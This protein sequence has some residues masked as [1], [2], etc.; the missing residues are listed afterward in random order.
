[1]IQTM[2]AGVFGAAAET[3]S[4]SSWMIA[5]R[6]WIAVARSKARFPVAIS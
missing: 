6:V 4:G 5:E 3:G 1:M 2:L